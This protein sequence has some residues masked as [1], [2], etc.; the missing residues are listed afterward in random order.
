M[1][2]EP[3]DITQAMRSPWIS[4]KA[5]LPVVNVEVFAVVQ[6]RLPSAEILFLH[7]DGRGW[8]DATTREAVDVVSHWMPI[9]SLP[10]DPEV[11]EASLKSQSEPELPL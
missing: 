10:I 6:M 5:K 8:V 9:P 2:A 4:V 7:D 1:S 3:E 11:Y